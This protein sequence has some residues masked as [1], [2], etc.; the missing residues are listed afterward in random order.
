[1]QA[2][3]GTGGQ[4]EKKYICKIGTFIVTFLGVWLFI[5]Y[6]FPIMIPFAL[7]LLIA[8]ISAPGVRF[9]QERL[10]LPRG[11]AC[12]IAV[13]LELV[14]LTGLMWLLC[15]LGYREL[16]ALASGIP[17]VVQQL[18]DSVSRVR[19]W[20]LDLMAQL[21]PG[22]SEALTCT[23]SDLFTSG[24]ILL[25]KAAS[26]AVSMIG[27]ML[28]GIPGG[29]LLLGTAV[30]SGYMIAVQLPT[31]RRRLLST[32]L[33]NTHAVPILARLKGTVGCWLKAQVKL[34]GITFVI[35]CAG[36]LLLR[37]GHSILWALVIALVDAV[38]MLGTGTV[39]IPWAVVV[40]LQG[41]TV[42]AVGL[43]GIYVTAMLVRSALE[44]KL[45]GKQLGLN[46]LLTLVA[47][48]AGFRLWGV[49]GMILAP[50]LVVTANQLSAMKNGDLNS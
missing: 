42:R 14:L 41:Q 36:L 4:L 37:T 6:L 20:L 2:E 30:I 21:P 23:V 16:T 47:L 35:V 50:I 29:A 15:A 33:W 25:E 9:L 12:F 7:G 18:T 10:H 46:P 45:L 8:G 17:D 26:G 28:G 38:P 32:S 39:L 19:Q 11:L 27:T 13:T 48:Y 44:P 3:R 24:S 1:M 49:M 40:L 43:T 5:R 31:L 34:A 22:L